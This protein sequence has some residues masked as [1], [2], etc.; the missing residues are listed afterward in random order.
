[1]KS[2]LVERARFLASGQDDPH[3]ATIS[4]LCAEIERL[5]AVLQDI[6]DHNLEV[7]AGTAARWA[8]QD[9][10]DKEPKSGRH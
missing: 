1:M 6:A 9:T 4:E 10:P 5:R 7:G 3:S 2:E 8:L